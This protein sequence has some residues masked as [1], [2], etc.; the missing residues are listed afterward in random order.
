MSEKN[1]ESRKILGP[2][3]IFGTKTILGKKKSF[4]KHRLCA[5]IRFLVYSVVADFGRVLLVL[6]NLLTWVI[7]NP[8]PQ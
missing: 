6:V 7:R 8:N 2:N 3:K 5:T 1:F 4:D